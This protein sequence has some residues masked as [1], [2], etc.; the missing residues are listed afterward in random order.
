MV[1]H[2]HVRT[3]P[4]RLA[5]GKFGQGIEKH[6]AL[7][8]G[9]ENRRP[10]DTTQ[11]RVHRQ[12]GGDDARVSWHVVTSSGKNRCRHF[13]KKPWSVPGF[14]LASDL[15]SPMTA[16]LIVLFIALVLIPLADTA[17]KDVAITV[18]VIIGAVLLLFW[19]GGRG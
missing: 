10:V 5:W 11:Y 4:H 15:E 12:A 16:F 6:P 14:P 9:E 7:G 13:S 19:L 2:E 3:D 17:G 1:G 18:G 8:V